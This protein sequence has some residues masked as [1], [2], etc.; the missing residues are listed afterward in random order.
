MFVFLNE[1]FPLLV[2]KINKVLTDLA[3]E[4][5]VTKWS[6]INW[7]SNL[8]HKHYILQTSRWWLNFVQNI[9]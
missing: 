8:D 6:R 1:M 9:P 4:G 5:F 7:D 2:I 3:Y